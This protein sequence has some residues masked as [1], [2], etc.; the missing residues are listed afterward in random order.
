MPAGKN[1]VET[2]KKK[3]IKNDFGSKTVFPPEGKQ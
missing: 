1:E 2:E 3:A